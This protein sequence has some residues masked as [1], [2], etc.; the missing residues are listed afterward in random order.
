MLATIQEHIESTLEVRGGRPRIIGHRIRVQD[1]AVLHERRGLTPDEIVEAYPGLTLSDVH[2][3]LAAHTEAMD[4]LYEHVRAADV[5]ATMTAP[6]N[7]A[8]RRDDLLPE[9]ENTTHLSVADAQG[10]VVALTQSVGP[11]FGSR[12]ASAE[13]GFIHAA[14]MEYLG[15]LEP[16]T[17]RHWSSRQAA[18]PYSWP[19]RPH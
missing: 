10:N 16:G 14:T 13:L 11:L 17:R 1:V 4:S 12:V 19:P 9:P 3:A 7:D 6:D 2:A 8:R 15:A 18:W 5:R